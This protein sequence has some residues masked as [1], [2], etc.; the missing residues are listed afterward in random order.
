MLLLSQ[1]QSLLNRFKFLN[2]SVT[3]TEIAERANEWL[4][5]AEERG[6]TISRYDNM[7]YSVGNFEPLFLIQ[8]AHD[9]YVLGLLDA[10]PVLCRT[11]LEEELSIR[12]LVESHLI[13]S[14]AA[15]NPFKKLVDGTTDATLETL[16]QW[17][18]NTTPPILSVATTPLARDIQKAGNDYAHAYAMRRAGRSMSGSGNVFTNTTAIEIYEKTLKVI[19]QMP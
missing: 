5:D 8:Q 19:T 13:Q 11:A 15:G 3:T 17:A 9:A 6:D 12:Y 4:K 14:V 2:V 7:V 1:I 10:V 16:I 18:T